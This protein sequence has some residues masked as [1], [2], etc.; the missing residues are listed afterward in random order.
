LILKGSQRGG[1]TALGKHLLNTADNE[2]VE[3]HE[4][5]GFVS[6]D[7][8][9][10][11]REAYAVSKGTKCRQ[12]IFSVSLSPPETEN[13]DIQIFEQAIEQV[14]ER[15]GLSG[16]PRIVVFH[17]K[18]GRRHA[19]AAWSRID[20]QQMKAVNMAFFKTKLRDLSREIYLEQGWKMPR[21]L[22]DSKAR[23][24]LNYSLEEYQQAKR[25]GVS[26]RDLKRDIQECYAVS[27]TRQSFQAALKE[28]GLYLANGRRGFVAIAVQHPNEVISVPRAAGKKAKEVRAKL[29]DLKTL[30]T[31]EETKAEIAKAMTPQLQLLMDDAR[32]KTARQ[33]RPLEQQRGTLIE[34]HLSERQRFDAGQKQRWDKE[35]KTRATR[36][37]S[38]LRGLWQ[39]MAGKRKVIQKQ[40]EVE[41]LRALERDRSQRHDL[42]TAQLRERQ[43][44]QIQF[45]IVRQTSVKELAKIHKD[46][47]ANR[48]LDV[49]RK[50]K[51]PIKLRDTFKQKTRTKLPSPKTK[52]PKNI[53][54]PK[55]QPLNPA[56]RLQRLR[57]GKSRS[58]PNQSK[59]PDL[60]R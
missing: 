54:P 45:R 24:P 40:N 34:K 8:M 33:L 28:R 38:G 26:A 35:T 5:R 50:Q 10:A 58:G 48:K 52:A 32:E 27:D 16:Q 44:L 2:H 59:G 41:A 56:D 23:D 6:D 39:V 37:N 19:H 43:N 21:G 36:L 13:V 9:G 57:S 55:S 3:L 1:A 15:N 51:Q 49:Q 25:M 18:E 42:I 47:A 29:G 53:S 31:V 22:M 17:E 14:E 20:A 30:A 12:H 4:I 60:E 11:M 46:I 7:L